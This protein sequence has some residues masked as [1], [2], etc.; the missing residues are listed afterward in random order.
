MSGNSFL[1]DTNIV[2][3]LLGGDDTLATMLHEKQIHLSCISQIE[4][5]GFKRM[6]SVEKKKIDS[7]LSTCNIHDLN[8]EIKKMT[9]D[10]RRRYRIKV[11]DAII[12]ATALF[13]GCPL[14]TADKQFVALSEM[15]IVFYER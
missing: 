12:A 2:L 11:P 5:L 13:N 15:E 1:L 10:I 3:Y 9:I 8:S 6:T 14:V 7:F 4:L